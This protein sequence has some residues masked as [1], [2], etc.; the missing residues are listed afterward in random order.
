LQNRKVL[1]LESHA[2]RPATFLTSLHFI[3]PEVQIHAVHNT[4]AM[5]TMRITTVGEGA[6]RH[7]VH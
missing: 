4:D 7:G 5:H 2:K 3:Y 6:A 1:S